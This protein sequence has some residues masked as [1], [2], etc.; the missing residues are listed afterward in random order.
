V[1][2]IT[3]ED[4]ATVPPGMMAQPSQQPQAQAGP[5]PSTGGSTPNLPPYN[6]QTT[7]GVLMTDEGE[8]VP[9]QSGNGNPNYGNYAAASHVE[10]Q[11]AIWIRENQ[12]TGGTV[13]HNNIN[14][15]CG[16]CDAQLETLL[17]E[18]A[19][20][21]VVPPA[22]AVPNNSRAVATPSIYVGNANNPKPNPKLNN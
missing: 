7:V 4:D 15:T 10:G 1:P 3:T 8:V 19:T 6:G 9:L 17:P 22:N 12:S 5:S 13:Y 20:L 11:A 2:N 16:Y 18:N 21:E 14:G